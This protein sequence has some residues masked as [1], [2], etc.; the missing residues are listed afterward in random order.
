MEPGESYQ[1]ISNTHKQSGIPNKAP[2]CDERVLFTAHEILMMQMM[3]IAFL[4]S[5]N[6]KNTK[7]QL[8]TGFQKRYFWHPWN[9]T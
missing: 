7:N 5:P 9:T 1:N 4:A 8:Q 6:L 3:Q 2:K